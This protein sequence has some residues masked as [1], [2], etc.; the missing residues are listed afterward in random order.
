[1]F[2]RKKK[3]EPGEL[4]ISQ[5]PT[6]Y[7]ESYGRFVIIPVTKRLNNGGWICRVVLEEVKGDSQ[8]R[9]YSFGGPM[10]EYDSEEAARQGGVSFAR[11]Q[12]KEPHT[13]E[14]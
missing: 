14:V 5:V 13:P 7:R 8:P 10:K 12:L 4:D 9:R 11:Q 1:M 3:P 2:F 6:E